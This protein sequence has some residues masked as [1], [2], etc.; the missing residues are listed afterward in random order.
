VAHQASVIC[1]FISGLF[2]WIV[3]NADLW[4]MYSVMSSRPPF[5]RIVCTQLPYLSIS[6]VHYLTDR[7]YL[8]IPA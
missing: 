7:Q 2:S 3:V 4:T 8:S 6:H 1:T 5:F